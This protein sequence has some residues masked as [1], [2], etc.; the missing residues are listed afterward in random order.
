MLT[1]FK[2]LQEHKTQ[3]TK[4]SPVF[5]F[6]IILITLHTYV[7]FPY[8][9]PPSP[10]H[11]PPSPLPPTHLTPLSSSFLMITAT[12]DLFTLPHPVSLTTSIKYTKPSPSLHSIIHPP[13]HLSSKPRYAMYQCHSKPCFPIQ[14]SKMHAQPQKNKERL[15]M[16]HHNHPLS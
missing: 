15:R 16:H 6:L 12:L 1:T 13:P 4:Q 2:T 7:S 9:Q 11:S 14:K 3:N 10:D 5:I 8:H